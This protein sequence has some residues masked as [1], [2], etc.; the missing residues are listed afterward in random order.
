LITIFAFHAQ[1]PAPPGTENRV[2]DSDVPKEDIQ[3]RQVWSKVGNLITQD[4]VA[5][6]IDIN[7]MVSR[8]LAVLA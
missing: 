5:I 3:S 6:E 8:H 4:E 2:A 7:K 1:D